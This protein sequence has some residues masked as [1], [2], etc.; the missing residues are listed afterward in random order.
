MLDL[1]DASIAAWKAKLPDDLR[2]ALAAEGEGPSGGAGA[3]AAAL[4]EAAP[5]PGPGGGQR[6]PHAVLAFRLPRR[7]CAA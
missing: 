5:G 3:L 4:T 1:S 2:S 7:S 6:H